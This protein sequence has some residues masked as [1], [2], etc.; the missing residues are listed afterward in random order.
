VN[1]NETNSLFI[2]KEEE[3]QRSMSAFLL[4]ANDQIV[5]LTKLRVHNANNSVGRLSAHNGD[6]GKHS[7]IG[8]S[9][10]VRYNSVFLFSCM[11]STFQLK[12]RK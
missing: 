9:I 6:S 1:L 12:I 3:C 8:C 5:R 11:G 2:G 4:D 10:S 7:S